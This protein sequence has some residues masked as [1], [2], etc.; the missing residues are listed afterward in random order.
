HAIRRR[1]SYHRHS[2]GHE[3]RARMGGSNRRNRR[4]LRASRNPI[5]FRDA[6]RLPRAPA[7]PLIFTCAKE[8]L[9][10][11]IT[12]QPFL[13]YFDNIRERT[14]RVARC[15][16]AEKIDWAPA[17]GK[18]TLGDLLRHLAVTERLLWAEVAQGK[19]GRYKS[20][21]VELAASKDEALA[22]MEKLH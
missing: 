7:S 9:V 13:K 4:R 18:F 6:L 17:P 5:R 2:T 20:H 3:L 16:P 19:P 14:M 21:S 10:E 11:I 22:L 15:I 1:H 12:I 8:P